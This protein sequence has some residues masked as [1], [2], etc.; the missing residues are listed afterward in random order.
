MKASEL[1]KGMFIND[2]GALCV[3]VD[4]EHRTPGNWRASYQIYLKNLQT[5]RVVKQRY[6]PDDLVE[7]AHLEPK[8]AQYLYHDTSGF[9]F[10]EMESYETVLL[11]DEIVGGAKD[12]IKENSEVDLVYYQER[13]VALELPLRVDLKVTE[14]PVGLKGDTEGTARKSV[15]LETGLRINAPLFISEGDIVRVDTTN[16]EYLGRI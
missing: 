16:G 2:S 3:V 14:A 13:P 4:M 5:G 15:V 9:H 11:S 7:Q 12:Y 1:K 10:M 6:N 8:K